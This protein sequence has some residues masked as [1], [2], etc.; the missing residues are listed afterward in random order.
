[1]HSSKYVYADQQQ[2]VQCVA[3]SKFGILSQTPPEEWVNGVQ[4]IKAA[5]EALQNPQWYLPP[6]AEGPGNTGSIG[7]TVYRMFSE[8]Y[9]N[10]WEAFAS[11]LYIRENPGKN[12]LSV[13]YIHN[14]IHVSFQFLMLQRDCAD[15]GP[16][17]DTESII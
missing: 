6:G 9:F 17:I 4:N 2:W 12:F 10:S 3:T 5:N 13:E 14:N 1:M 16:V 8:N 15:S 7:E 11:T